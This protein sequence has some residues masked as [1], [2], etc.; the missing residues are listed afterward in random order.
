M[1]PENQS[2]W[3]KSLTRQRKGSALFAT[4]A[5]LLVSCLLTAC[6]STSS[7]PQ[8][9]SVASSLLYQPPVLRLEAG[10]PVQTKDGVYSPQNDEVWHSDAR[11]RLLEQ[12][13]I[14][15]TEANR[16]LKAASP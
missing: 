1:H 12:N 15:L 7:A 11:F 3:P 10:K 16:R 9:S 8:Q 2:A 14:D 6:V 4:L 13:V 5:I